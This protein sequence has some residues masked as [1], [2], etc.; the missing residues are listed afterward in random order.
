MGNANSDQFHQNRNQQSKITTNSV[1]CDTT[2]SDD[3]K[4]LKSIERQMYSI[5]KNPIVQRRKLK[6]NKLKS[7]KLSLLT[8][9]A[10]GAYY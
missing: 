10:F 1:Q 5:T 9:E 4:D 8:Y 2:N 3:F 7:N 6:Q